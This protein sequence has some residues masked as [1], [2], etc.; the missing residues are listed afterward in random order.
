[1]CQRLPVLQAAPGNLGWVKSSGCE[2]GAELCKGHWSSCRVGI[3]KAR[4]LRNNTV[5]CAHLKKIKTKTKAKQKNNALPFFNISCFFEMIWTQG[6]KIPNIFDFP[7]YIFKLEKKVAW[8]LNSLLP[9]KIAFGP[10][11]SLP[12][13]GLP[14][15][16]VLRVTSPSKVRLMTETLTWS[17]LCGGCQM[18]LGYFR[19]QLWGHQKLPVLWSHPCSILPGRLQPCCLNIIPCPQPS[20]PGI[21]FTGKIMYF[22]LKLCVCY[23]E[24]IFLVE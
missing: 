13:F 8:G 2:A 19:S 11:A 4:H 7:F 21:A 10:S 23:R 6:K 14:R 9:N 15:A 12:R 24:R 18:L 17:Y 1:M 20:P 3:K 5:G 22:F 16:Q